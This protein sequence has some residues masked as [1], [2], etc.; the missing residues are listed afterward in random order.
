[1]IIRKSSKTTKKSLPINPQTLKWIIES[2]GWAISDLSLKTKINEK[3]IKTWITTESNIELTELKK[4][5]KVLKRP[6]VIFYHPNPPDG[7]TNLTKYRTL[8]GN[9][10]HLSKKICDIMIHAQY[11][12]S[13]TKDLL[14]LQSKSIKPEI[15]EYSIDY[16]AEKAAK[17]ERKKISSQILDEKEPGKKYNELRDKIE[18]FNIVVMQDSL[19]LECARGVSLNNYPSTI[20]VNSKDEYKARIFTLL[21]EYAHILLVKDSICQLKYD[22]TAKSTNMRSKTEKWCNTFAGSFLMPKE[23]FLSAYNSKKNDGGDEQINY[24]SKMFNVSKE[25]AIVRILNLIESHSE[26]MDW[27]AYY[28]QFKLKYKEQTDK[29]KKNGG[30]IPQEILCKSKYGKKYV[31]LVLNSEKQNLITTSKMRHY[32][33]LKLKHFEKLE[34]IIE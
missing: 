5:S 20:I 9:I 16:N 6:L 30:G 18:S 21:Y 10:P 7:E 22:I 15:K 29:T 23:E 12:Q 14:E 26:I 2:G 3:L 27:R 28:N 17:N 33:D 34:A 11:V 25:S 13:I 31:K 32:L 8:D 4:I 1:M 24:L 19:P